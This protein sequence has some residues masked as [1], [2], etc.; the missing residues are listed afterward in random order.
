M[1]SGS[2]GS[3][4]QTSAADR[5]GG[6]KTEPAGSSA[7]TAHPPPGRFAQDGR[8]KRACVDVAR[9]AGAAQSRGCAISE[10][11]GPGRSKEDGE[12][13]ALTAEDEQRVY[14]ARSRARI[15]ESRNGGF[16]SS[17]FK[18]QAYAAKET[19]MALGND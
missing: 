8:R 7:E 14:M 19:L 4:E 11:Q 2:Y 9:A 18:P 15:C 13:P 3:F 17:G 16:A 10:W 5:P 6:K 12:A 1:H